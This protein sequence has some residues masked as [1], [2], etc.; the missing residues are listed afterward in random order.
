MGIEN[1]IAEKIK[2]HVE[3]CREAKTHQ[4]KLIVLSE[5]LK[6]FGVKLE[7]LIP[8]I[9]AKL[10]SKL[11]GVRG[12]ADLIFSNVV[13]EV[14]TDLKRELEAAKK[15]L[16]K[17]LQALQER[18]PERR[19]V[20][21]ATDCIEFRAYIPL[22]E[23]GRVV[24]LREIGSINIATAPPAESFLW[25]DSYIFS[26]PKIT[27]TAQDLKSRFGPGSPT[28]AAVIDELRRLWDRVKD[29]KDVELKLDLWARHMEIVYGSR[30]KVDSFIDHTYLV[31]LVKLIVYLRL[32]GADVVKKDEIMRALAGEYFSTY[33]ITNFIE[34]D[35]FTWITHPKISGEALT[36]F[37]E[38]ARE[39]LRY[40]FTQIDEDFF[41]EIYQEIVE[42]GQRHRIGEYY[43]PEWLAQLVLKEAVSLWEGRGFP[44]VLDPACGSGTF[45]YNAI[46]MAREKLKDMKEG[47]IL[48]FIVNNIVGVDIN[49]LAA[50]IARA[51]Y[52]IALGDLLQRRQHITIPVYIADSIRPPKVSFG[53]TPIRVYKI[54]VNGHTIEI[55]ESVVRNSAVLGRVLKAL[56]DAVSAY[57]KALSEMREAEELKNRKDLRR[58]AFEVFKREAPRQ[59][60]EDELEVLRGTLGTI[61]TL[62]DKGLD[63]IWIFILNNIYA[64]IVLKE[65]KFDIIVGN[66]PWIVMRSIEN[67]NYQDF[68]KQ[69]VLEYG[70]LDSEQ[71]HLFTHMEVATLFFAR[72]SDLYLRDGG[73]TAF[74]M[75]RSVLTGAFHHVK[76]RQFKKPEMRLV[77]ILDLEDVTPLFNVPS[78]ALIAAKG[79]KTEYPIP[80]R[81]Y[82][83]KLPEKNAKLTEAEKYL[84]VS[85]YMYSPPEIPTKHSPYHNRIKEGASIVPRSFWFIDFDVHKQLGIDLSKPSVKSAEHALRRADD[86]WKGIELK[87]NVEANFIYATLLGED[88]VPFGYTKLRPVV[89]PIEPTSRGYKLL[90]VNDLKGRGFTSTAKWLEEAQKY[91]QTRA[92]ARSLKNYPRVISWLDYMGK[93]STQNPNK[94]YVTLYNASGKNLAAC[95]VDRQ[96][97]P[98]FPNGISPQ[99]FVAESKSYYYETD[100]EMEAHYLCA[101]VNSDA[102]NDAIKSIQSERDIQR[103]PF[104]LPIPEY[105]RNNPAHRRL[106]ELSKQCHAKVTSL[107][108]TGGNLRKKIREALKKELDEI[109][110]LVSQLI[111]NKDDPATLKT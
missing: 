51:N 7:E 96:S 2:K 92:T 59:L 16:M 3:R 60:S 64:P 1:E 13:F 25:L 61:L 52:L 49:P 87:G 26:Q 57:R 36:L 17:Y 58:Y 54:D 8:G 18:E 71:T 103:R 98:N 38:V 86:R 105:D 28:Y 40:D 37:S 33:G 56:K 83:G 93:L 78:C 70:L 24:D 63:S 14:K 6:L 77:K 30:P 89:L 111:G 39:L 34:E 106:A 9:E 68:I 50:I 46:H 107:K 74:V 44:R 73:V 108:L 109:N 76:F 10:G 69:Q 66:P 85:D 35:F 65:S 29:E 79:G 81:K 20:G 32:S 82:A 80:A 91:W 53:I 11:W 104:M 41:K 15:Q 94:R 75:P 100:D 27:P 90:D 19:H 84:A 110:Q 99:G 102:I 47:E 88:I 97:L 4:G 12:S 62:I 55:P 48:N 22:L 43:T 101:I 31:T 23:G 21:I 95:V 67:E 5:L 72:C 42:R 45:L